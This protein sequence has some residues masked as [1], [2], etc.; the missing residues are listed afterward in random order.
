MSTLKQA[1]Y[2]ERKREVVGNHRDH[3]ISKQICS[4]KGNITIWDV[5][6]LQR[7]KSVLLEIVLIRN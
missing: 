7:K 5:Y 4:P 6:A 3:N 1:Y 2:R